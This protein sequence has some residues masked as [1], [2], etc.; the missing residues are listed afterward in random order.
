LN[1]EIDPEVLRRLA[2]RTDGALV[3]DAEY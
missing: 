1:R 3:S 2:D